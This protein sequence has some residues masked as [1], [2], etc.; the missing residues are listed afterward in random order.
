MTYVPSLTPL[1]SAAELRVRLKPTTYLALFDDDNIGSESGTYATVDASAGVKSVLNGAHALMVSWLGDVYT[2]IPDGTDSAVPGLL[3]ETEMLYAISSSYDRSPEYVRR[4]GETDKA[5]GYSARADKIMEGVVESL[6]RIVDCPPETKP[7][8]AGGI[9][10][11][12]GN[13]VF[14]D[15]ADGTSNSGDF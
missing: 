9:I 14:C 10:Y 12:S 11:S 3:W 15:N 6:R 1:V 2:K 13:R 4:Y 8:N 5:K 7:I